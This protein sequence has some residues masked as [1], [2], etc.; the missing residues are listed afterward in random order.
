[1]QFD[2]TVRRRGQSFPRGGEGS[3]KQQWGLPCSLLEL[4]DFETLML[5]LAATSQPGAAR[6][7]STRLVVADA[8]ILAR[9][10][11]LSVPTPQGLQE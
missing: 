3:P 6:G 5:R 2:K 10:T 8:T 1:M 7:D 4:L 11:T 9:V